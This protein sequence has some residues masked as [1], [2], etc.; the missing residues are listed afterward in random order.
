MSEI[1]WLVIGLL[2]GIF[3]GLSRWLVVGPGLNKIRLKKF[4][5]G[6][7]DPVPLVESTQGKTLLVP[8]LVGS[9]YPQ[10]AIQ[11]GIELALHS[12][13]PL[14]VI[15]FLEVPR[16]RS[17]ESDLDEEINITFDLLERVELQGAG[18][19][20]RI[21]TN[22]TKVRSYTLALLDTAVELGAGLV[23]LEQ[24]SNRSPLLKASLANQAETVL[25][26][27]GC[28]VLL[29]IALSPASRQPV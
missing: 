11:T 28:N 7:K 15:A 5:Q 6:F 10:Q 29:V 21:H 1:I 22:L 9:E 4:G 8:I 26:K 27:I 25:S 24:T 14:Y 19:G 3:I 13:Q 18:A 23:I 12:R 17:L 16:T 20:V 2:L